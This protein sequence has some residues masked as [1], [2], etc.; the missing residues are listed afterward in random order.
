MN[1]LL[2]NS[3][4]ISILVWKTKSFY[5]SSIVAFFSFLVCPLL[6][7]V[8]HSNKLSLS[9]FYIPLEALHIAMSYL[10]SIPLTTHHYSLLLHC[11]SNQIFLLFNNFDNFFSSIFI[12]VTFLGLGNL[13][14]CVVTTGTYFLN[15]VIQNNSGYIFYELFLCV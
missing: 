15:V 7:F 2:S 4:H 12:A 11:T 1:N 8:S 5:V 13:F 14:T 9:T 6:F 10:S 3:F